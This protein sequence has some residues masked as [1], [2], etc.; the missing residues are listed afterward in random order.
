[1]SAFSE[2][3]SAQFI[4]DSSKIKSQ[5]SSCVSIVP[6]GVLSVDSCIW[7]SENVT[8][9]DFRGF[10]FGAFRQKNGHLILHS[11]QVTIFLQKSS[12]SEPPKMGNL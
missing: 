8:C 11:L 7:Y 3:N 2:N 5:L 12:K 4:G 6:E 9:A 10:R 1:M